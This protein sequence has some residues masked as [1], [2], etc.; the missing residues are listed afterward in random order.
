[1]KIMIFGSSGQ[2]GTVFMKK[3]P[4]SLEIVSPLRNELNLI[5][6][7]DVE[8]FIDFHKPEVILN[9]AAFTDVD[10]SEKKQNLAFNIN[11]KV[12]SIISSCAKKI[13]AIFFHISTDYVY[14][15]TGNGYISEDS[16]IKP[17]NIYGK[18]KALGE[19]LIKENCNK[20]IILRTSWLYSDYKKNFYKTISKRLKHDSCLKVVNDQIGS[21]TLMNDLIDAIFIIIKSLTKEDLEKKL[22][23]KIWGIYNLSNSGETSWYGFACKIAIKMGYSPSQKIIPVSSN[24]YNFAVTRP[25]NS[26]LD[27]SKIRKT[28]GIE[29]PFWEDSFNK[30]FE[31]N[32]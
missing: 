4:K 16:E 6:K 7:K 25:R 27:N 21:P 32:K 24:D 28:F 10:Q 14:N 31:N 3:V 15:N 17:I 11:A 5:K 12:P 20:F 18:S 29:L 8:N 19:K 13:D 1:M 2:M 30:F 9:F 23:E 22:D 26:R